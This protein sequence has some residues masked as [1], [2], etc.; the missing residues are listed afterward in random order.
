M[1]TTILCRSV[2]ALGVALCSS[3]C[4]KLTGGGDDDGKDEAEDAGAKAD[5]GG[6][7]AKANAGKDEAEDAGAKAD[8]GQADSKSD[9]GD[10]A[11]EG[12][13]T[14]EPALPAPDIECPD[15]AV[16][17]GGKPPAA[18]ELYCAKEADGSALRHGP[19][20]KWHDGSDQKWHE[21]HYV[22]G[23]KDG[24]AVSWHANG[25]KS[26][27]G[28][29]K[30]DVKHGKWTV[31]NEDG[32]KKSEGEYADGK[33]SGTWTLYFD[34]G[35]KR[36]EIAYEDDQENGA[37]KTWH[38]N[39]QRAIEGTY[40]AGKKDGTW[41]EWGT[42]GNEV[43]KVEWD[44]GEHKAEQTDETCGEGKLEGKAPPEGDETYCVDG[45]GN[46]SGP[47]TLWHSATADA[48]IKEE[49]EYLVG[50][51]EGRWTTYYES[52]QTR[53]ETDYIA[54]KREGEFIAYWKNGQK[55]VEGEY[56]RNSRQGH[57]YW[58]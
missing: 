25:N 40:A 49:G 22:D 1:K 47:Y 42:D 12:G 15:G 58:W 18:L 19:Y 24:K 4:D 35:Q 26:E 23:K 33:K 46:K 38:D 51:K 11:A 52:G 43:S 31:W 14:G 32:D 20:T 45:S 57:W 44:N 7:D 2:L 13:E 50:K 28:V 17:K 16:G 34:G 56:W 27:E 3:G 6:D 36:S 53:E 30:A 9:D 21:E 41:T 48:K 29:W 8:E 55:R 5:D 10:A 54:G 37:Y 39:G